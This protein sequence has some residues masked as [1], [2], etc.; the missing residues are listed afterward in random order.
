MEIYL[1]CYPCILRQAIEA[2]RMAG[3][4]ISQQKAVV[5]ETLEILRH[6]PNGVTPPGIGAH[7]HEKVRQITGNPDPY[8]SV[9]NEATQQ[10]LTMLPKLR[11][12]INESDDPLET[13]IRLSIAGNIIDFGPNPDY[14]LWKVVE[15]V[16]S[17]DLSIND[18]P[19]LRNRFS[20]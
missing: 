15:R 18:L 14:D 16:L 3:A 5:L 17:M 7:V 10:A 4:T 1:D 13:A 2:S 11:A 8:Q 9:K 20:G 6:L 12:M 19:S